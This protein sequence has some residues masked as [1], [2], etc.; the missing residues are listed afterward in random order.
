VFQVTRS[1]IASSFLLLTANLAFTSA[2]AG[3]AR[4]TFD[5]QIRNNSLAVSPDENNAV[6]SYSERSEVIVYDL[7]KK[8]IRGVLRDFIT[9]R[10][11]VFAPSGEVFYISDSSLGVVAKIDTKTLK[12]LSRLPVGP[13][14][15]GT[16]ISK[17][18]KM[19]YVDNQ[20]AST[21]PASASRGPKIWV[22]V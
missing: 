1:V 7:K 3:E 8:N 19:L 6:A 10:N 17:D 5:G 20:A 9:P 22:A 12:T 11:I 21:V 2:H 15:F 4:W 16:T 14:A 18:G 13:G